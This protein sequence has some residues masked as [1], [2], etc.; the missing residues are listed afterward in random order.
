MAYML[1]S[2]EE[3]D[4]S[5]C[6]LSVKTEDSSDESNID[7]SRYLVPIGK[8]EV[9]SDEGSD[10]SDTPPGVSHI[11]Y[12]GCVSF[13][14]LGGYDVSFGQIPK[15][16]KWFGIPKYGSKEAA[17][18][19]A[20]NWR[21]EES[22]RR[23]LNVL[24]TAMSDNGVAIPSENLAWLGGFLD[25]DGSIGLYYNKKQDTWEPSISFGQ[26]CDSGEPPVL[27]VCPY[28]VFS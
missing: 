19:A 23:G 7:L 13:N 16:R 18:V 15:S 14:F 25:G 1:S 22:T 2:D 24:I 26:S 4:L 21:R 3:L 8:Q 10:D 12:G 27:Q 6:K 28:V 17:K 9:S 5:S 11:R 20:E